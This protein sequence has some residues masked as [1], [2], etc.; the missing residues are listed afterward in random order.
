MSYIEKLKIEV[1]KLAE[2]LADPHPGL[3]TWVAFADQRIA[4]I[5]ALTEPKS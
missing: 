5:R 3:A 4:A 2:L 1:G